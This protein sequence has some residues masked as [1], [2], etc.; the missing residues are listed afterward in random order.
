MVVELPWPCLFVN[1]QHRIQQISN[2]LKPETGHLPL[3]YG[4]ITLL[5]VDARLPEAI[6][7]VLAA[8]SA[9]TLRDIVVIGNSSLRDLRLHPFSL[10]A[11]AGV[12]LELLPMPAQIAQ[13]HALVRQLGRAFAHELGNPLAGLKG[14]SQL[15]ASKLSKRLPELLEYTDI[16]E[17][18]VTRIDDLLNRM[19]GGAVGERHLQNIH[20]LVDDAVRLLSA[21][22]PAIQW[23]RDFDPS[24]PDVLVDAAAIRQMLL[25]LMLNGAQ[26][27]SSSVKVI[28]RAE[29]QVPIGAKKL[30][31][32]LRID[33]CDNGEGVPESLRH[34]LFLPLVTGRTQGSGFGL[35]SALAIIEEHGGAIRFVSG[36]GETIF[37]V[38]LPIGSGSVTNSA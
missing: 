28:T 20:S 18:E 9:L 5:S 37:S 29:H 23:Q 31:T 19:R 14:V 34:T 27:R 32:A 26:A 25:N 4:P 6:S 3:L 38:Y 16:M 17:A 8:Q 11:E 35:A 15:L 30:S 24:L 12:L 22:F 10:H 13:P 33:V 7:R 1:E 2:A 21:Q 36:R